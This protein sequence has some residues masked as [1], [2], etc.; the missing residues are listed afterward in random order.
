[1]QLITRSL[2]EPVRQSLRRF[3]LGFCL[4]ALSLGSLGEES[5]ALSEVRNFHAISDSLLT[6][7]Q[8]YP[9]QIAALKERGIEFVVNL[10]VADPDRN[11]EEPYAMMS[12]GINYVNIPVVWTE[13]TRDDLELFFDMMDARGERPT[14]VHCF[15]NYRASAFTYLYRVLREGVP[16]AEAREDLMAVWSDEYFAKTPVWRKFIDEMLSTYP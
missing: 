5:S 6:S 8:I 9:N 1:M 10:A 13:P 2:L 3:G 14:L 15:A 11:A 7:G 4:L 12:N 16:E